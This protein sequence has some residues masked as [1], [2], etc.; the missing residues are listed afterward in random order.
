[1]LILLIACVPKIA[2]TSIPSP[3][4]PVAVLPECG[5]LDEDAPLRL[6]DDVDI[7]AIARRSHSYTIEQPDF[8]VLDRI[9]EAGADALKRHLS[10]DPAWRL[11]RR[12][13]TL[14]AEQRDHGSVPA[15]G[16]HTEGD[17]AWRVLLRFGDWP[18]A[19]GWAAS[20]FISVADAASGEVTMKGFSAAEG[21]T[22]TAVSIR[23]PLVAVELL[24]VTDQPGRPKTVEAMNT[25]F[26]A[27]ARQSRAPGERLPPSEHSTDVLTLRDISSDTIE[28]RAWLNPGQPGETWLRLRD[29]QGALIDEAAVACA[30]AERIGWSE[31]AL[32]RFYLQAQLK[33]TIPLTVT[34]EVWFLPDGAERA[35]MIYGPS[36]AVAAR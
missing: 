1:M 12:A 27:V 25:L 35:T 15:S 21:R 14:V 17:D 20:P 24:E 10:A 18:E 34:A 16:Y 29:A 7:M 6:P 13:G 22:G 36:P 11:H 5:A 31:E 9:D 3:P 26:S 8:A 30:T 4:P 23:G 32:A 33:K 19:A 28:A 2:P